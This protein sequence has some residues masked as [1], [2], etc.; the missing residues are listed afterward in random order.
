MY[1]YDGLHPGP[2]FF[3]DNIQ[4]TI[5]KIPAVEVA[6]SAL[7][8][9]QNFYEQNIH[10]DDGLGRMPMTLEQLGITVSTE[11]TTTEDSS[12]V[13][14]PSA[15]IEKETELNDDQILKKKTLN[16]P[17]TEVDEFYRALMDD[18]GPSASE[19]PDDNLESDLS[20]TEELFEADLIAVENSLVKGQSN[21]KQSIFLERRD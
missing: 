12:E 4:K 7:P 13:L 11:T 6:N 14:Q 2:S 8:I 18:I 21:V 19:L 9:L 5:S 3:E 20:K 1:A 16:R 15:Q 17:K 10:H